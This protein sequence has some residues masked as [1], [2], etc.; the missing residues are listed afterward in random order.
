MFFAGLLSDIRLSEKSYPLFSPPCLEFF[1][2]APDLA[3]RTEA[4]MIQKQRLRKESGCGA[5]HQ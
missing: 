4:V 1:R 3:L 2:I 5:V